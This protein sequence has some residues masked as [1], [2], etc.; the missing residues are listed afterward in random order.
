MMRYS[1]IFC[2]SLF[3]LSVLAQ[4]KASGEVFDSNGEPVP[5]ANVILEGST[6]GTITKAAF[7]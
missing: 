4:T 7:M 5:F 6:V 2:F 1:L 3:T